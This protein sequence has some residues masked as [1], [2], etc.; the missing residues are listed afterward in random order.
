MSFGPRR[1]R[2]RWLGCGITAGVVRRWTTLGARRWTL[3]DLQGEA[4]SLAGKV[5]FPFLGLLASSCSFS[6]SE[7]FAGFAGGGL[8]K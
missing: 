3:A 6:P 2:R 1:E 4:R 5:R 7:D 8:T